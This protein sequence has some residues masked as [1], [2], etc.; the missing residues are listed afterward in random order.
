MD[1]NYT[2]YDSQDFEFFSKIGANESMIDY[3]KMTILFAFQKEFNTIFKKCEIIRKKF[4]EKYGGHWV[5]GMFQNNLNDLSSRYDKYCI[6]V[7]Y[8]N[9]TIKIFKLN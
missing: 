4:E 7:I 5:V 3:A 1:S 9:Y 8:N 6:C 2:L